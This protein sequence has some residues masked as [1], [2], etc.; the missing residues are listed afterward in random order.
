MSMKYSRIDCPNVNACSSLR[1]NQML[2]V[3]SV[4]N[5]S[6]IVLGL[7]EPIK[8]QLQACLTLET[9]PL[10]R[11][12]IGCSAHNNLEATTSLKELLSS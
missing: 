10:E 1:N 6:W 2:N 5:V 7:F 9:L 8:T 12:R 4:V 3:K 11:H